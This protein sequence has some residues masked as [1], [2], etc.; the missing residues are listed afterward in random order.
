MEKN[1][2]ERKSLIPESSAANTPGSSK[3]RTP[4]STKKTLVKRGKLLLKG[5]VDH[6]ATENVDFDEEKDESPKKPKTPK[7]DTSK[8]P[9]TQEEAPKLSAEEQI[10]AD[11]ESNAHYPKGARVFGIWGKEFYSAITDD[12]DGLGRYKVFYTED[13]SVRV[14][15]KAGVIP[16]YTIKKGSQV[17]VLGEKYEVE[18]GNFER[19]I[20][21]G[22]VLEI[23]SI[24]DAKEWHR[25]LYKIEVQ[26]EEHPEPEPRE[27]EWFDI[28]FTEP[29]YKQMVKTVKNPT[30][31][32]EGLF[33]SNSLHKF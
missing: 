22:K 3:S 32:D 19:E 28:Y 20:Y 1:A 2:T 21:E 8:P 16:L 30:A 33:L 25:G 11:D 29:Q 15:P 31:V 4:S 27:I 12:L 17:S 9:K 7:P 6:N 10:V 23:P 24:K 5:N 13:Q 14:I 26:N 18:E